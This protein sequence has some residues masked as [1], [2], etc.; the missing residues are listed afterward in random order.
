MSSNPA[1]RLRRPSAARPGG[2][3]K[4]SLGGPRTAHEVAGLLQSH[5]Q[6]ITHRHPRLV[7][8]ARMRVSD[9]DGQSGAALRLEHGGEAPLSAPQSQLLRRLQHPRRSQCKRV[10][11]RFLSLLRAQKHEARR[12]W[13]PGFEGMRRISALSRRSP[14]EA[15]YLRP[16]SQALPEGCARVHWHRGRL[17]VGNSIHVSRKTSTGDN[18]PMLPCSIH[19]VNPSNAGT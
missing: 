8:E 1:S 14:G 3:P 19:S 11:R 18:D 6:P 13:A 12:F 17:F 4:S 16:A 15:R 2:D 5:H 10:H 9:P 7:L